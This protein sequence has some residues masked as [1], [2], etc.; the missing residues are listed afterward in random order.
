MEGRKT[1][2]SDLHVHLWE[3]PSEK[4]F[5]E[6]LDL[7]EANSV[8]NLVLLEFSNLNFYKYG[9]WDKVKDKIKDHFSGKLITGIEFVSTIDDI[10]SPRTGFE[11]NGYRSDIVLYDF[12]PEKLMP[13]FEDKYLKKLW[14]EDCKVFIE[15]LKEHGFTAPKEIYKNDG[16]ASSFA[17]NYMYY[18]FD[19]PEEKQRFMQYFG[20]SKLEIPSD[21]TRNLMD[22]CG[23]PLS[24]HQKLY[25]YSSE[26]FEIAK[27]V[28]GRLCLAHP[29]YMSTDFDT[30]DYIRVMNDLSKSNPKTRKP[31]EF[32]SGPY[33][34]DR[35]QDTVV[36]DRVSSELGLTQIPT[37]DVKTQYRRKVNEVDEPVMY[38]I[39]NLN[40]EKTRIN[41]K[42]RP[43]FAICPFIESYL[44]E[45]GG[46]IN[47]FDDL[48][49]AIDNAPANLTLDDEL[50]NTFAD[51][52]DYGF[53]LA[54]Y[55][56]MG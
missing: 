37:S 26:V 21:I 32:V 49:R 11:Y 35:A 14:D 51:V 36:I 5:F 33:M 28:G 46:V 1:S 8:K 16:H 52:R 30:E 17:E 41:Y 10:T 20:L 50:A 25:T 13:Y 12:D 44:K 23:K 39:T 38:C 18:L 9:L 31:F 29:A 56:E 15:K 7:A 42:P 43:G 6:L 55:S 48:Q 53:S 4:D 40:G 34:L 54:N 47:D 27:K 45:R 22:G 24:Y 2:V 19:H 3:I